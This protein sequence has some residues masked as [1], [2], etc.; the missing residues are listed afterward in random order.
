MSQEHHIPLCVCVRVCHHSGTYFHGYSDP[1]WPM[2]ACLLQTSLCALITALCVSYPAV[3]GGR[4]EDRRERGDNVRAGG[5]G[6]KDACTYG[7]KKCSEKSGAQ[8]NEGKAEERWRVV[9]RLL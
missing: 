2:K 8:G 6:K 3:T 9:G 5:R 1:G 7:S 4:K